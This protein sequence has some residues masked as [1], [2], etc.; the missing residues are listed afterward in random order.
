MS[1]SR[2]PALTDFL[3]A[4]IKEDETLARDADIY[5]RSLHKHDRSP[6]LTIQGNRVWSTDRALAECAAKRRIVEQHASVHECEGLTL[7]CDVD[8]E[9][10]QVTGY[11]GPCYTLRALAGVYSDHP[12]CRQEWRP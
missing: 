11:E 6:G 8:T 2:T 7:L 5:L 12:D 1:D 9:D 3:L 4:R 10:W